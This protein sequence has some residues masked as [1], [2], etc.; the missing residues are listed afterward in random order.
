MDTVLIILP[1][2]LGYTTNAICNT[3]STAGINVKI[4]PPPWVFKIMW[5]IL[6]ILIGI[7][8]FLNKNIS[9]NFIILILLLS[10]WSVIYNCVKIKELALFI[11]ILSIISSIV[12]YNNIEV[13]KYLMLP[14][15][16]WLSFALLLSSLEILQ[17]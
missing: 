1:A 4:R 13:R 12:T 2:L 15:I 6:Y 10:S 11:I 14:L 16:I 17:N 7:S 5:P 8:W 3:P 9:T